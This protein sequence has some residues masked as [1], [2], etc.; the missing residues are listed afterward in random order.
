MAA[1]G[2]KLLFIDELENDKKRQNALEQYLTG[3]YY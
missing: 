2:A 3:C 1:V